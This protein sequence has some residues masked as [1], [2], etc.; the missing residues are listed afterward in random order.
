L[1][2]RRDS[3]RSAVY[4][5]EKSLPEWPGEA[6]SLAGCQELVR[7]VWGDHLH[8]DAP[9]VTDGRGRRRAC[10]APHNH[11]IRLPRWSRTSLVVLHEVAHAILFV[12]ESPDSRA[13]HGPEFARLYLN[14]L[15]HYG[16]VDLSRARSRAVHQRPRRVYFARLADVLAL[17]PEEE[18][19]T[20]EV[21]DSEQGRL[22]F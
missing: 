18:R 14:F 2:A 4:A 15:H 12:S 9:L 10:Y 21:A 7:R 6:L 20:A 16:D 22:L 8:T 11:Q 1:A 5:W 3:Q 19:H 13:H 17:L